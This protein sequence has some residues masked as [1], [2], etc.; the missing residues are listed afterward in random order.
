MKATVFFMLL[1]IYLEISK[2]KK[3]K[4]KIFLNIKEKIDR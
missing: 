4:E 1:W 3:E 2:L